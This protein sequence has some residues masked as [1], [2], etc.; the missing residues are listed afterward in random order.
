[1]CKRTPAP[2]RTAFLPLFLYLGRSFYSCCV[3]G[4]STSSKTSNTTFGSTLADRCPRGLIQPTEVRWAALGV[5]LLE[6]L[7]AALAGTQ[8]L[9]FFSLV[10]L[11]SVVAMQEFF[12]RKWLRGHFTV[13]V[14]SHELLIIPLCL[15]LYSLNGLTPSDL[16]TPFFWWL[17]A[18]I[19]CF[20][21]LLEVARKLSPE[22]SVDSDARD[23]YTSQYGAVSSSL[24]VASLAIGTTVTGSVAAHLLE[25]GFLAVQLIGLAFLLPVA[26]SLLAFIRRPGNTSAKCVLKWCAVLAVASSVL[27]CLSIWLG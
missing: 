7:P 23:T 8:A 18:Y 20:L 16:G 13:Y 22:R 3:S 10:A 24:L 19:G 25:S 2:R 14:I 26:T 1:M 12:C 6:I 5:F 17:T 21:F 27:F 15:Y 9:I 4:W 11:Y